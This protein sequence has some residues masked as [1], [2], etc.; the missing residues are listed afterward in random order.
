MK[1]IKLSQVKEDCIQCHIENIRKSGTDVCFFCK[2]KDSCRDMFGRVKPCNWEKLTDVEDQYN[3]K[4]K[5]VDF[6]RRFVGHNTVVYIY[7]AKE[8]ITQEGLLGTQ[9]TPLE[10]VMEWQIDHEGTGEDYW[11]AHPDVKKS[12]YSD[13]NVVQVVNAFEESFKERLDVVAI[14][15]DKEDSKEGMNQ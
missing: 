14:V 6:I 1:D 8:L 13:C 11:K 3:F 5:L 10:K 12:Q 7:D 4:I 2:H 9:Y 15:I